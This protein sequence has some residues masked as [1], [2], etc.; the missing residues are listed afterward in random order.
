M[1]G[2]GEAKMGA[3]GWLRGG[4]GG[5]VGRGAPVTN[6]KKEPTEH[7][8]SSLPPSQPGRKDP[9]EGRN[10]VVRLDARIACGEKMLFFP[11]QVPT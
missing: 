3:M 4:R 2:W 10:D 8:P 11:A 9:D 5:W 6:A 1:I 7:A